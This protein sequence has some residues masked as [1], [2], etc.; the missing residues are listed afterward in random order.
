ML[1][2]CDPDASRERPFVTYNEVT[3][4]WIFLPS[5]TFWYWI[6]NVTVTSPPEFNVNPVHEM[7]HVPTQLVL[8]DGAVLGDP[9]EL[10][11][12]SVPDPTPLGADTTRLMLA[13]AEAAP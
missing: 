3:S 6:V 4:A 13:N 1:V 2:A 8:G 11:Y 7:V 10:K 9:V 12:T 5:S